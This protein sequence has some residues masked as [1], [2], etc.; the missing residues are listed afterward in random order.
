M[1]LS[2]RIK[3]GQGG[4]IG[5]FAKEAKRPPKKSGGV[6]NDV[7]QWGPRSAVMPKPTKNTTEPYRS[8]PGATV[9]PSNTIAKGKGQSVG[10]M[11]PQSGVPNLNVSRTPKAGG[12]GKR[13]Y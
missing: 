11:R 12:R 4:E 13:G 8:K 1:K 7:A 9:S 2:G 3:H 6:A 10:A 5:G